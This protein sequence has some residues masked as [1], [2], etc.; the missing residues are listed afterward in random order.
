MFVILWNGHP[1]RLMAIPMSVCVVSVGIEPA[2]GLKHSSS[3]RLRQGPATAGCLSQGEV[4]QGQCDEM[5]LLADGRPPVSSPQCNHANARKSQL[6]FKG[7]G[8]ANAF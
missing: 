1:K 4:S 3:S 6:A 7:T 8:P 2:P 5:L